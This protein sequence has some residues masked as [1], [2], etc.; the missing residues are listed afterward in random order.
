MIVVFTSLGDD[1][2][3]ESGRIILDATGLRY[4][5]NL[6]RSLGTL[7]SKV[8]RNFDTFQRFTYDYH[9]V[10]PSLMAKALSLAPQ[11][12]A[13]SRVRADLYKSEEDIPQH[14]PFP[15]KQADKFKAK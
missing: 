1:G 4:P 3:K 8:D 15:T 9:K 12:F 11:I 14:P 10:E 5:P 6:A 2:I 7:L 13:G